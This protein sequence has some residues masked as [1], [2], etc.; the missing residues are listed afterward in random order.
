M[1]RG[2]EGTASWGVDLSGHQVAFIPGPENNDGMSSTDAFSAAA[3]LE[4]GARGVKGSASRAMLGR[5]YE[6][7]DHAV[8]NE[9]RTNQSNP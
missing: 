6:L 3:E 1:W 7:L 2:V 9:P 5:A 4:L 8:R